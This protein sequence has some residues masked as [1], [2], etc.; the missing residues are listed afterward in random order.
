MR[1]ALIVLPLLLA[2]APP[3]GAADYEAAR[4]ELESVQERIESLNRALAGQRRERDGLR[5]ALQDSER[6]V[7][8]AATE[9]EDTRRALDALR[10]EQR[11]TGERV[12]AAEAAL[13]EGQA[14]LASQVRAAWLMGRQPQ[15]RLL[16]EQ[17]GPARLSRLQAYFER[18]GAASRAQLEVT[19]AAQQALQ[20]AVAEQAE[21]RRRLDS[22]ETRQQRLLRDLERSREER[23]ATLDALSRRIRDSDSAL[24][25]ARADEASLQ[26][27]LDKL[28][29]A[30]ADIPAG[31]GSGPPLPDLRGEL[32]W[33]VDGPVLAAFGQTRASGLP[34]KGIWIGASQGAPVRAIASGRVAWAGWMHRY[35]LVVIVDHGHGYY[36]LYG[37]AQQSLK[38]V[39]EWVDRGSPIVHAGDSG[40]Q[41][42][43]GVY[44]ELRQG[45]DAVDPVGWL[46]RR[47]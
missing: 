41:E 43:S 32:P 26:E 17:D 20:Q 8:A 46:K 45:A 36:S 35:G 24:D 18:I 4:A 28:R 44:L 29:A 34:W 5:T 37:H 42:R 22:A 7:T 27:L 33:P 11:Q 12:R 1:H 9:L 21:T 23:S 39:G 40:G 16:L 3:A 30:L 13:A 19:I 31:A 38:R 25:E 15:L 2:A 47:G 14:R 10:A 6:A